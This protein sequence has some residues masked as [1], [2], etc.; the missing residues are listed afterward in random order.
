[1]PVHPTLAKILLHVSQHVDNK[2]FIVN[3]YQVCSIA[4]VVQKSRDY[5]FYF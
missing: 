5:L 1:M 2:T 4:Y 3:V